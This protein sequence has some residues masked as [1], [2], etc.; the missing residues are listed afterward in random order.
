M[1]F[2]NSIGA[3]LALIVLVLAVVFLAVGQIDLKVGVLIAA[4]AL[5]RIL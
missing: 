3:V 2:P 1:A 4:L 5:A